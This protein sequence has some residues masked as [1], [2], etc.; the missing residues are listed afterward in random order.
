MNDEPYSQNH[1]YEPGPAREGDPHATGGPPLAPDLA[2]L[3]RRLTSDGAH[4]Q[5]RL[6]PAEPV[7]ERIRAIP[8]T[9]PHAPNLSDEPPRSARGARHMTPYDDEPTERQQDVSPRGRRAGGAER[10][11]TGRGRLLALVAAVVIVA[12]LGAVLTALAQR[13]RQTSGQHAPTPIVKRATAT[14]TAQPSPTATPAN[15]SVTGTWQVIASPDQ[16]LGALNGIAAV[17]ATDLWAVGTVAS[18]TGANTTLI[19]HSDGSSWQIVSSPN[20]TPSQLGDMLNAVAAISANDVWAVGTDGANTL[21]EHWDG[22]QW[23]VIP[24]PSP[25]ATG[26]FLQGVTALSADNVWAAGYDITGQG[27]EQIPEPLIEH[28]NG[29]QWSV[30][31]TPTISAQYGARLY[32]I[33]A[34]SA[35][36]VW[37]VG[38]VVERFDGSAWSL[39]N[40][41]A[42]VGLFGV[43]ALGANNV[44]T[45]GVGPNGA[46][47]IAHWDGSQLTLAAS[48]TPPNQMQTTLLGVAGVNAN[49]IW[50][51]GGNPQ[52]GCAGESVPLIEHWN[53]QAWSI[54]NGADLGAGNGGY[55]DAVVAISANN[56]WAVGQQYGPTITQHSLI[57]HYTS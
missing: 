23:S 28:W 14:R 48:P 7:A 36:D 57:E 56:V 55:L 21:I 32:A 8:W 37:A 29:T 54:V 2:A 20:L 3:D 43:G 53:G 24:S 9:T 46:P 40:G 13:S 4:W 10:R 38:E 33:S 11:A 50:A 45:V 41:P 5:R 16:H 42:Q 18:N 30:A 6:P 39:V 17:S 26:N 44:W 34:D 22:A 47:A 12:L 49:D 35:N 25:S 27:C 15:T 19:E 31:T 51:V 1:A 52:V